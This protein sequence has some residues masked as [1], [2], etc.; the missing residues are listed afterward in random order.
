[1]ATVTIPDVT[2]R[3]LQAVAAAHRLSLE[4]YLAEVATTQSGPAASDAAKQ[5][6]AL[7][8]FAAG[9]TAWTSAHLPAGHIVDD[10]RETIYDGRGG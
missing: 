4:A 7:E 6:A 8:S 10:S 9:M 5:I 3:R 1:M 2:Y